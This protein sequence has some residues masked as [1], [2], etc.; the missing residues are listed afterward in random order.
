VDPP[1]IKPKFHVKCAM[2]ISQTTTHHVVI[3]LPST[4]AYQ[5]V[6]LNDS[7]LPTSTMKSILSI[8]LVA[9]A[10]IFLFTSDASAGDCEGKWLISF[11]NDPTYCPIFALSLI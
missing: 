1:G 4:R 11:R 10:A 9:V 5:I 3:L 8:I 7:Q 6:Q 2:P